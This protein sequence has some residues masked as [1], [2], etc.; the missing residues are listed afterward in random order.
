MND[1]FAV[2]LSLSGSIVEIDVGFWILVSHLISVFFPGFIKKGESMSRAIKSF[3]LLT[4]C[5]SLIISGCSPRP[6]EVSTQESPVV[7]SDVATESP[8]NGDVEST[9]SADDI[10]LEGLP[11]G[12]YKLGFLADTS[13]ALAFAGTVMSNGL[14]LAVDEINETGFLGKD[15][16][17]EVV[18]RDQEADQAKAVNIVNQFVSDKEILGVI[19]GLWTATTL[20]I[21]PILMEAKVPTIIYAAIPPGIAEPPYIYRTATLIAPRNMHTVEYTLPIFNPKTVVIPVTA[22]ADGMITM[23]DNMMEIFNQHPE[24]EVTVIDTFSNDT[25]FTGPA[26]QII[27]LNPDAVYIAQ[28]GQAAALTIKALR[29]LGY[30]GDIIGDE[31]FGSYD[32]FDVAGPSL[33]GVPFALTYSAIDDRPAAVAFNEKYKSEFG[34]EPDIYAAEAYWAA[35]LF[36]RGL[37]AGGEPTRE[38]LT[39]GL[40]MIDEFDTPAGKLTLQDGQA[41]V[42]DFTW[43]QWTEDG[44]LVLWDK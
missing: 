3:L 13:G 39:R 4:I 15:V 21:K 28:I 17:L 8:V 25:D 33:A 1:R 31:V 11:A 19:G 12:K 20:A 27:A 6:S 23:K 44:E 7:E 18:E 37:K 32:L 42:S 36:A 2:N 10:A 9:K 30:E 41:Y 38:G 16:V 40:A 5:L 24:I 26:T 29:E 34:I 14:N 35:W 43:A 22:D